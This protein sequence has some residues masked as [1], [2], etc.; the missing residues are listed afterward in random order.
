MHFWLLAALLSFPNSEFGSTVA[1]NMD[2]Y[3]FIPAFANSKVGSSKGIVEEEG[4]CLWPLD[5]KNDMKVERTLEAGHV[6]EAWDILEVCKRFKCCNAQLQ[7]WNFAKD[8]GSIIFLYD[9]QIRS[10]IWNT[11]WNL[12]VTHDYSTSEPT[13]AY[14]T[15]NEND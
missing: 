3:W 9:P 13:L 4:T 15:T 7:L 1:K 5:S 10:L 6:M 2:L 14:Q 8:F 12:D 11:Q